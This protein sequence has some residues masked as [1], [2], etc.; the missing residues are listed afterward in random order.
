MFRVR[1]DIVNDLNSDDLLE[2]CGSPDTHVL[3]R[4]ELPHG[5]PHFHLWLPTDLTDKAIRQRLDRKFKLK[6][7]DRSVKICDPNRINE[8]VQ[9]MF[10]TKHGNRWEIISVRNFDDKLLNDLIKAAKEI[11]DDFEE[12]NQQK[13]KPTIY[14]LAMEVRNVFKHTYHI[15][16]N[17]VENLG[18]RQAPEGYDEY[19]EHLKI[20]ISVC[21]K[22]RQPFEENYLRRL[23][24]T[25]ICEG[26]SGRKTIISK[27]MAKEF[28]DKYV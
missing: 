3:V 8:Y 22:H 1:V 14:S 13:D 5:N 18:K 21:R 9:Y 28:P 20:A 12:R 10:N 25:A 19:L 4:H 16:D 6:S 15:S 11:S 24:T 26:E 7:T 17:P 23:I 2:V 27:I